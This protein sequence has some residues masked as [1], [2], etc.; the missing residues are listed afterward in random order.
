MTGVAFGGTV[1]AVP[2]YVDHAA[3]RRHMAETAAELIGSRG[4]D[5][6]TFRNV[7]EA[8][9]S[10]T[11]VL[12]HYFAD[13]HDLMMYTYEVV[14]E[15]SGLRF[16]AARQA[17]GGLYE[18][19]KVLLPIDRERQTEWRLF[20]CYWALAI[21]DPRL[22]EVES[23]HVRSAQRRIE[24]MLR[25]RRPDAAKTDVELVARRLVTLVHGLGAHNALDPT[26]WTPRKQRQ[27][28]AHEVASLIGFTG[29]DEAAV[30]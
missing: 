5:A 2:R 7:A 15:R 6:L 3:R 28:L 26:H 11:T 8:A 1:V 23:P 24:G 18:C 20:T 19:L 14:A 4:L 12:T 25:E 22:A 21:S 30:N 13:K 29:P 17:G 27:V 16:D 9:G 10:S